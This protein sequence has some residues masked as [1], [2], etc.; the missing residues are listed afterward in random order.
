ML[1]PS[2]RL[3]SYAPDAFG[4]PRQAAPYVTA[5]DYHPSGQIQQLT[6]A[7]GQ[8]TDLTLNSRLWVERMHSHGA[9][10]AMDLTYLYDSI[11]NVESITDAIDPLNNR[12]LVYD[13]NNRLTSAKGNGERPVSPTVRAAISRISKSIRRLPTISIN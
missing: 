3:L 13:D 8:T 1:Y 10:E 7:N 2:G 6:Y 12:A 4:R 9:A 5:V 11:G